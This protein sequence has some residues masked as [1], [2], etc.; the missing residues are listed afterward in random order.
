MG[1]IVRF[2]CTA[3]G[4]RSRELLLGPG[5]SAETG[6][7]VLVSCAACRTLRAV[8]RDAVPRGCRSHRR[9]FTVHD[10]EAPVPCP[11]C[12]RLIQPTFEGIWD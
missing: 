2:T 1:A 6:V 7:R 3:C 5:S 4:Y 10:H 12:Q 9:L 8:A 11:R